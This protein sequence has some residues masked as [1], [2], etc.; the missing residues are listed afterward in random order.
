MTVYIFLMLDN[1]LLEGENGS[2]MLDF[3]GND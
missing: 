2:I 1:I 3:I